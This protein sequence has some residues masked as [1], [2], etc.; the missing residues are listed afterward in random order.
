MTT[1]KRMK[2]ID[3]NKP[4]SSDTFMDMPMNSVSSVYIG[5]WFGMPAKPSAGAH[6]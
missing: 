1:W 6:Q 5:F 3:A 4:V 2:G